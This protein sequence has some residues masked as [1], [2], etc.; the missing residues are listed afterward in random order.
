MKRCMMLLALA[1]V[2]GCTN[3]DPVDS[4][5]LVRCVDGH[6]SGCVIDD[7]LVL[8][9]AHV[10]EDAVSV[11]LQDGTELP[12]LFAFFDPNED[13]AVLFVLGDLPAPLP[14][15]LQRLNRGDEVTTIGAPYNQGLQGH[16]LFGRVAN[17]GITCVTDPN[18]P[19]SIH[20]V[21]DL[22]VGP[23]IS[24]APVLKDGHIVGIMVGLTNGYA[25]MLPMASFKD[26]LER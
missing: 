17:V 1:L 25:T 26:L 10:A 5:V 12:V 20:D 19:G 7:H 4:C 15:S 3:V 22:N 24:G 2:A 8:T 18:D 23:G 21:L 16:M 14:V 9:A 13:A 11:R 6:G